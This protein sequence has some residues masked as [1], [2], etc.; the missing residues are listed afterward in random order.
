MM[1]ELMEDMTIMRPLTRRVGSITRVVRGCGQM[2][3]RS[4]YPYFFDSQSESWMYFQ[5][6]NEKPFYHF[7]NGT[8]EWMISGI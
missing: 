3:L 6:G 7:F 2:Q 5:S 8:K 4:A 1:N